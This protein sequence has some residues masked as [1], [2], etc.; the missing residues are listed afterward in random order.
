M[1]SICA[2][3]TNCT[4]FSYS[5]ITKLIRNYKDYAQLNKMGVG[6]DVH[7]NLVNKNT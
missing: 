1:F 2:D 6:V 3:I 5:N 4:S 7:K